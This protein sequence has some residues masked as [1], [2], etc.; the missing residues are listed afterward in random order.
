MFSL[1]I[2]AKIIVIIVSI[3]VIGNFPVSHGLNSCENGSDIAL[4][5]IERGTT[6]CILDFDKLYLVTVV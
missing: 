3:R 1:I 4:R 6:M 2:I 5:V